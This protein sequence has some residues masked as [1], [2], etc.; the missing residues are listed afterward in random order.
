MQT[1]AYHC[2][3]FSAQYFVHWKGRMESNDRQSVHHR[4]QGA[5]DENSFRQISGFKVF[6]K[7]DSMTNSSSS[8][9][10]APS[11]LQWQSLDNSNRCRRRDRNK[12]TA[13]PLKHWHG[14]QDA[15]RNWNIGHFLKDQNKVNKC[16]LNISLNT[17]C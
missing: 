5:S 4:H 11:A 16:F 2:H 14:Y 17:L 6:S 15:C 8:T 13:R 10:R 1:S 9:S 12:T 7:L 3:G